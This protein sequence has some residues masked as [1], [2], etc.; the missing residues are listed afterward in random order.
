MTKVTL[1]CWTQGGYHRFP[2]TFYGPKA[3]ANA[4]AYID[5]K[6]AAGDFGYDEDQDQPV[7]YDTMPDLYAKIYPTCHHGMDAH[8]CMDPIGQNHWGTREQEMADPDNW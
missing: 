3:E 2:V 7:D 1:E 5:R 8:L 4:L 6:V